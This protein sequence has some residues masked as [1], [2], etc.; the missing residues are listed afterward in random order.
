METIEIR[1]EV[2]TAG[3]ENTNEAEVETTRM[4]L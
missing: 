3:N 1:R 2:V 4:K